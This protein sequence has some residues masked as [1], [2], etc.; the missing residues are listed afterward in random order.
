MSEFQPMESL[1]VIPRFLEV[2]QNFGHA[3]T[4]TWFYWGDEPHGDYIDFAELAHFVID[5]YQNGGAALRAPIFMRQKSFS[6]REIQ[7]RTERR[8][9]SF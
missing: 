1:S 9:A 3:G 2:A 5:S 7:T 8:N 6:S 4:R